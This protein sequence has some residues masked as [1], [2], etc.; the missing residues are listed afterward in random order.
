MV[1]FQKRALDEANDALNRATVEG[2]GERKK[3]D[4]SAKDAARKT[5]EL[6]AVRAK[7]KE[8]KDDFAGMEEKAFEVCIYV[9]MHD[10]VCVHGGLC[11][12]CCWWWWFAPVVLCIYASQ[13][14]LSGVAGRM[15]F[16]RQDTNGI[17]GV[18]GYLTGSI[19]MVRSVFGRYGKKKTPGRMGSN[20]RC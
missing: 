6:E 18:E 4:K 8:A 10:H 5:K 15:V 16:G 19:Y 13:G 12:C 11:C 9:C 20:R 14:V 1:K 17:V 2:E 3:G 7:A